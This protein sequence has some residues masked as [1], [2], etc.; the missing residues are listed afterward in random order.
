YSKEDV[1]NLIDRSGPETA[2]NMLTSN[3]VFDMANIDITSMG[4]ISFYTNLFLE[5][6]DLLEARNW[7]TTFDPFEGLLTAQTDVFIYQNINF[8]ADQMMINN[9]WVPGSIAEI[10]FENTAVTFDAANNPNDNVLIANLIAEGVTGA[11]GYGFL[12]YESMTLDMEA[13]IR[14]YTNTDMSFNLAES[15]YMGM[16]VL[17][18]HSVLVGDPKT[19]ILVDNT[20]TNTSELDA[21][22]FSIS[23]NP[24]RAVF[25]I[26][27]NN[28]VLSTV[29]VFNELGQLVMLEKDLNG[30]HSHSLNL[31]ELS[32]GIYFLKLDTN[33][34]TSVERIVK[35]D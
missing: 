10:H 7:N 26:K 9:A 30:I 21:A 12:T 27:M 3:S 25:N 33:V 20:I 19:S 22:T 16:K 11:H 31:A 24:G 17:S 28:A 2:V 35:T 15:F 18:L 13:V 4:L 23:P 34:G 5:S 1:F 32:N 6:V 8:D 29:R 14:N